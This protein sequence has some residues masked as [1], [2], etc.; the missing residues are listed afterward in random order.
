MADAGPV[1][2]N[3]ELL[4]KYLYIRRT[5]TW[6]VRTLYLFG[7]LTWLLVVWGFTGAIGVDWFYTYLVFPVVIL[8]TI[9]HMASFG[10]QMFY[11][12]FDLRRHVALCNDY[13]TPE[14]T[15]PSIDVFLPICG[16]DIDVLANTWHYV[17]ELRYDNKQV[18]VLDDSKD[19]T[20]AHKALAERHGFM[21]LQRPNRGEMKK[22]GNLKHA[23]ERTK[24][25]F[26]VIFD[27]DFA[28]HT[29]FLQE[30]LPHMQDQKI[31]IV[32]TPQYFVSDDSL[33]ES[34]PLQYGAGY[35]EEPFY[36][37]IQVTRDR[38]G[39][40]VCCGSNAIYRRAALDNI[41]GP[42]QIDYS[43]DAQ[44]GFAMTK[45]GWVVRYVPI[46]LAVGLCPDNAH[47][48]FHQQHRWCMGS[49]TLMLD[50]KFWRAPVSWQTKF[51][52][53]TGFMFYLS[54]PIAILFSFQLFW[55]LF[56]YNQYI[57][58]TNAWMFYPHLI[59]AVV[60]LRFFP[61]VRHKWGSLYAML[62]QAYSYSHGVATAL[63]R[64]SVGWIPTNAKLTSVS[65][66]YRQI[67]KAVSLYVFVYF[68]L[69]AFALRYGLLHLLDVNYYSV[70]FW[71]FFNLTISCLLLYHLYRFMEHSQADLVLRGVVA[72]QSFAVWQLR[73]GVAYLTLLTIVFMCI[74]YL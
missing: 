69:I 8:F 51:C 35:A 39:G 4:D 53:V 45:K 12:Q 56:F 46:I 7:I 24:G 5:P 13:W 44:T 73:T 31:G 29:D 27:A 33:H 47:S 38:F 74:V 66:A 50:K 20:E 17:R 49:M 64:N 10:L 22:A 32:Q 58:L 61:I 30:L 14:R 25:E 16:E 2:P 65:T 60:Y 34:S 23:Y 19:G 15:E 3:P 62:F 26:I 70:Q 37:F 21:Y 67:L 11:R 36:R 40:T 18:Y 48:Y 71:I 72:K 54:H 43:E 1:L 42:V 55:A 63:L 68:V 41:G 57:S 28:P 59:F 9:Y 6:K 52:Y